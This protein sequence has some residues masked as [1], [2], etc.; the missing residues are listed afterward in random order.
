MSQT[1]RVRVV[2]ALLSA[3]LFFGL[4]YLAGKIVM[5]E[6][7]APAW[8]AMRAVGAA[9]VMLSLVALLRL[10]LPRRPRDWAACGFCA[11]FGVVLNQICFIEGLARTSAT[12]SALINATIPVSALMF[13]IA[14]RR[15]QFSSYKGWA[16]GFALGGVLLVIAPWR[17]GLGQAS[18]IG[19]LLT[20]VNACS[21]AFFLV[22]SKRLLA[23]LDPFAATAATLVLGAIGVFAYGVGALIQVEPATISES[24][25]AWGVFIVLFPTV[26]GYFLNNWA[27]ARIE[28]SKVAIFCYVQ[29]VFVALIGW[30]LLGERV[31]LNALGGAVLIFVGVWLSFRYR[32]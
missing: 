12:H 20:L 10:P 2:G 24:A 3:Q 32:S 19:D 29:P 27:L 1:E 26:A 4:H 11:V 31:G 16:L 9:A 17:S 25:W 13:A 5:R 6:I 18:L 30:S 8:A 22:A 14:A 15:E 23:S 21:Y 28:P 7:P